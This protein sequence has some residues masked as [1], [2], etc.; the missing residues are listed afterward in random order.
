ML[1]TE[2]NTPPSS[3]VWKVIHFPLVLLVIGMVFMFVAASLTGVGTGLLQKAGL[4]SVGPATVVPGA[5]GAALFTGAYLAFVKLVERRTPTAF[6]LAGWAKELG[7][8]LLIGF[9][10][11][12]AIV[13]VMALFGGYRVVGTRGLEVLW[14]VLGISLISGFP[15]EIVLRGVVFRLLERWLGSWIALAISALL[16]GAGHLAN[17]N[18]SWFAAICIAFEAGIMLAAAY[19]VT[20]RLWAAIGIHAAWNFTQGGIYG[21]A[22][23]GLDT[24]GVFVPRIAGSDLLTGGA[25][26]AE[27]SLPAL[28]LATALGVVLLVIA[29]RKGNFVAPFWMRRRAEA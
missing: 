23:S 13:G 10:I 12:S 11:F 26:G 17:P 7:A 20:R 9:L 3:T 22:I 2:P 25:F 18:A 8:G 19:M 5:L 29:H 1:P 16:F 15:E 28:I 4:P 27:A 21:I 14:P 6:G 24:Q